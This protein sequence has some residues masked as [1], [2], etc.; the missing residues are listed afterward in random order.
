[1]WG[2]VTLGELVFEL[3]DQIIFR[4]EIVVNGE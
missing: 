3:Y 1:M 2:W 4:W